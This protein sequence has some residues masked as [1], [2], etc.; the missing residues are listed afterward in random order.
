[1][2]KYC[3]AL[4]FLLY[5]T[6]V[7]AQ[8]IVNDPN[9]EVKIYAEFNGSGTGTLAFGEGM[10]GNKLY[11]GSFD[12]IL[13]I[14]INEPASTFV[15]NL[16]D[17][18]GGLT[19]GPDANG[20]IKLYLL[21]AISGPGGDD[22][23]EIDHNGN[24]TNLIS[25]VDIGAIGIS[26]TRDH[27]G[28]FIS[29]GSFFVGSSWS[30]NILKVEPSG[31]VSN[32][33]TPGSL[34]YPM[35]MTFGYDEAG[36]SFGNDSLFVADLKNPPESSVPLGTNT[37][38]RI[39]AVGAIETFATDVDNPY[40]LTFGPNS[41]F[42]RFLF[43]GSRGL[44]DS[45]GSGSIFKV[46]EYGNSS[47]FASGFNTPISLAFNNDGTSLFVGD[48]LFSTGYFKIYEI[49]Y[50]GDPTVIELSSF[51]VSQKNK[52]VI[53]KWQTGT[54]IDNLGFNILRS[55]SEDGE[56]QKI[57]KNLIKAKGTSTK[58]AS[59]QFK[60]KK[61][62]AGKTYWYKLEDIDSNTVPTQHD[63]VKVKVTAKKVKTK[64]K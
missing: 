7:F 42:G 2:G 1:M 53:I 22:I 3:L 37:I 45:S 29:Q 39:S 30:K 4:V 61:V 27:N 17:S 9:F 58:G 11:S 21:N 19:F 41:F 14:P 48:V 57:N 46:D 24:I 50:V 51:E 36:N 23:L 56:Y 62:K 25:N 35:G 64:K 44:D 6:T 15:S 55:E 38:V 34:K 31:T 63:A 16:H 5:A 32:L 52:K 59:Y 33:T 40:S 8:V 60:D 20:D 13:K 54:E 28:A 18:V 49:K 12:T 47:I 10:F 26:F 43:V